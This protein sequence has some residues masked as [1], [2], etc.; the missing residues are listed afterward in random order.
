MHLIQEKKAEQ[1]QTKINLLVT[2]ET[3]ASAPGGH[4]YSV[5]RKKTILNNQI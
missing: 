3:D 2:V 4:S 1:K 5:E